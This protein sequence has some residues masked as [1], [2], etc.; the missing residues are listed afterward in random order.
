[1]IKVNLD[2][3]LR[4]RNIRKPYAYL[5]ELGLSHTLA[6]K[7]A[8]GTVGG[9]KNY[10]MELLCRELYCTPN[11]LLEWTDGTKPLPEEHPLKDLRK[12]PR[13]MTSL[14]AMKKLPLEKMGQFR[15]AL[16]QLMKRP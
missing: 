9:L 10:Q 7:L 12:D 3:I 2:Y 11:D 6:H 14:E 16:D 1:M 15:E 13:V 8:N 5:R 4:L